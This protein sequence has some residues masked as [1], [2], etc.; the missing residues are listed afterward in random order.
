MVLDQTKS[1]NITTTKHK[2]KQNNLAKAGI[3]ARELFHRN[4][5]RWLYTSEKTQR[6]DYCQAI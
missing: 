3:S 4:L 6:I 5:K 2:S 1:K